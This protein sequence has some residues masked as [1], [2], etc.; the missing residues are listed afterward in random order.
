MTKAEFLA[1]VEGCLRG[2]SQSDIQKS[3][4]Y[5]SEMIDDRME[6]G[7]SEAD[8]VAA[9]GPI[10]EIVNQIL[11]DLP[12]PKLVRARTRPSR[13]VRMW[14]IL[15]LVLGSP[16]WLPLLL[17]PV[18]VAFCVY[19]TFFAVILSL[20]VTV[21]AVGLGGLLGGI[22]G[23]L[24]FAFTG[25]GVQAV[26]ILGAGLF[27]FGVALLLLF[28]CGW[29]TRGIVGLSKLFVRGIKRLFVRKEKTR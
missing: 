22:G 11:M 3:L 29:I 10:P 4:E 8:A 27:C 17:V 15:L 25:Q 23:A 18:V 19:I 1:A 5:Y 16:V 28:P 26:L 14:E 20:Y 24:I 2:L 9:M 6:E 21:A 7:M 12:L 13:T